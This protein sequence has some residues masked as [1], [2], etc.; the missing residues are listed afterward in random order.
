MNAESRNPKFRIRRLVRFATAFLYDAEL[1]PN[2]PRIKRW[3]HQTLG[4]A[5]GLFGFRTSNFFRLSGFGIRFF[6]ALSLSEMIVEKES[7]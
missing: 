4:H 2:I 5:S 7:L 1:R 6:V 3:C